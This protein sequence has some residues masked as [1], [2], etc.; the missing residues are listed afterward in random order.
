MNRRWLVALIGSFALL[1]IAVSAG[2]QIRRDLPDDYLAYPVLVSIPTSGSN[3]FGSG[4]YLRTARNLFLVT[5]SHVLFNPREESE[6]PFGPVAILSSPSSDPAEST[7]NVVE[8]NLSTLV[9]NRNVNIDREHDVAIVRL[10]TFDKPLA[11][12]QATLDADIK[13][14]EGVRQRSSSKGGFVAARVETVLRFSQVLVSN[15]IYIFGYP[16]SVGI[17][18]APQID[19][20]RPL[21]RA[22]IVAGLNA[23]RR[24]IIVDAAV[25]AGNSGGPVVMRSPTGALAV[26]GVVTQTVPAIEKTSGN[27]TV[28]A[29]SGYGIVASMDAV[30]DLALRFEK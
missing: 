9:K 3:T 14:F 19:I 22:G 6:T 13:P 5:A 16:V 27:E 4:F 28:R 20:T 11:S 25:N 2:G 17:V 18:N 23:G 21:L 29:N 26:I 12:G 10:S 30:L 15:Q 1:P 7:L 24:T 8:L